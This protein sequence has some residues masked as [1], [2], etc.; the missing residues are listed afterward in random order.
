MRPKT[1][2]AC[3]TNPANTETLMRC[4]VP[5]ARK[6]NAHLVGL[7]MLEAMR[8][9]P[10]IAMDIPG[11]VFA[12]FNESQK[13]EAEKIRT[14][15]ASHTDK[16]DFQSEFRLLG[17]EAMTATERMVESA[18]AADLVIMAREDKDPDRSDQKDAQGQVIR[19]S[20][21]PVIIVPPKYD[22][23]EIGRNVIVG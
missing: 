7:H 14:V 16:E 10:G 20:G 18:C 13:K 5:L 19:Y 21:R 1:M 2:L 12:A 22:G 11:S 4:A 6:H 17:A 3:L 23:P 15:F 9:Y 8:V